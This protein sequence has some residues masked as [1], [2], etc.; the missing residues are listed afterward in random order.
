MSVRGGGMAWWRGLLAT[1]WRLVVSRLAR[2]PKARPAAVAPAAVLERVGPAGPALV[3]REPRVED[4]RLAPEAILPHGDFADAAEA[5][6]FAALPPISPDAAAD[7]D[8]DALA[9]ELMRRA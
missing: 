3:A 6:R 8:W 4:R 1:A 2:R 7:V 9:R 5:D